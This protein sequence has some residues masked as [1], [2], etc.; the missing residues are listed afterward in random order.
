MSLSAIR[1]A[2]RA[3]VPVLI[4]GPPG[5]GKTA[6]VLALGQELG[7]PVE[8]VIASISDPTDFGGL[9]VVAQDGVRREPPAWARRLAA[10]GRGILFIDEISTAAP[11]VQAAL[12]RV[13]L[14]RCVGDLQLPEGIAVVAAANPPE[15][16]AGGW[17][18]AAPLANRFLHLHWDASV[19]DWCSWALTRSAQ[20]PELSRVAAFVR[21]RPTL[22]L[23]VPKEE[24]A[25]GK[26][27][28]SP[29]S[30]EA[31]AKLV[32]VSTEDADE[33]M[34]LVAGCVGDGAAVE[35]L[36]WRRALDLPDPE[37]LLA[38][39]GSFELP[40]RG[41]QQYAVFASVA[42]AALRDLT[43]GRWKA[44]WKVFA[45]GAKAGAAD[46]AAAAVRALAGARRPDLPLPVEELRPFAAL[47]KAVQ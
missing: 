11:A 28:P 5:I 38:D 41:D 19:E 39:P 25:A 14:D 31:A 47:L 3:R 36:A 34:A 37:A 30:W 20:V 18:L 1:A 8:V 10:A 43:P 24:T 6:R 21:A 13:V 9:P 2:V 35:Y 4:W 42:A 33:Q 12:L 16:A 27:W 15:Q 17:D 29:R 26:A 44:A 40:K 45:A 32:G 7:L 22:L 23:Q 46:V